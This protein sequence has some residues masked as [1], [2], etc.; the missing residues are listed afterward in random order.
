MES[1]KQKSVLMLIAVTAELLGCFSARTLADEPIKIMP[2]GNSITRGYYG[3][4]DDNGYRKPLYLNLT[5]SGY[6]IDFVGS[7]N[8]GDFEDTNHEGHDGWHA[9]EEGTDDDIVTNIFNWLVVNPADIVLL[10]IGTNDITEADQDISEVNDILDEIDSYSEDTTVILALII[11][12][13]PYSPA[14]TQFNDDLN[15]MA[16]YR[17]ANGDDIIIVDMESALDY[18][19][20]MYDDVHPNDTGYAKMADDWYDA[21][22]NLLGFAPA[23]TSTPVTDATIGWLYTYDVNAAACPDPEYTLTTYPSGMTIDP[24]T[25]LI[26]WTPTAVGDFDVTVE[27]SNGWPPDANQSFT[28]TV[29]T[30]I[31]FDAASSYSSSSDGTTLSWPHTIGSGED[32]ILVAGIAGE[33]NSTTDLTISSVTYNDVN[34]TLVEDSS[35]TVY[36]TTTYTKTELYYLL[37]ADLPL[38]GT[39]DVEVTYFGNVSESSGGAISLENVEQRDPEAVAANSNQDANTI[40]TN[41][42]TYTDGA[43]VIDVAGCSSSGTLTAT[44]EDMVRRW[45]ETS[46]SA[47]AAAGTKPVDPAQETNISWSFSDTNS[48]IAHSL[49]AFAPVKPKPIISGYVLEQNNT[50]VDGVLISPDPNGDSVL[51]DHNGRYE[52]SVPYGWSG[53]VIPTKAEYDFKPLKRTYSNVIANQWHR[54]YKDI[55]VYDLDDDGSIGWGD[56]AVMREHWLDTGSGI[57]GDVNN[58]EI[59]DFLDLAEF[60]F[61]W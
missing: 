26:E 12:R 32:R 58:D 60:I 37:D 16:L 40:S 24:D 49:V 46:A 47:S 30:V 13:V 28:I 34:M 25:G 31:R 22:D 59:V 27:V 15:D 3:S 35:E 8:D 2:L 11:N 54:N 41:T 4:T 20:D 43:W 38:S 17:I 52:V 45:H 23:I 57:E 29:S 39:Y 44:A 10:H 21:L 14:T 48:A 53:T 1:L 61:V 9:A 56:I 5:N 50:P 36:S 6:N 55:S 51:T 19:T 42:T 7:Q 33:D 18:S